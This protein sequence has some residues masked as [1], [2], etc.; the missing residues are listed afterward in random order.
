MIPHPLQ[1][2]G[3]EAKLNGVVV[4]H[5]QR[6]GELENFLHWPESLVALH[7]SLLFACVE[8][9]ASSDEGDVWVVGGDDEPVM[10]PSEDDGELDDGCCVLEDGWLLGCCG[11]LVGCCGLLDG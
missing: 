8:T 5:V 11:W 7:T 9:L 4:L 2:L 3:S 10:G 6:S 1:F